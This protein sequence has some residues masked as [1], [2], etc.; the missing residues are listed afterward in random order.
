VGG[1]INPGRAARGLHH[2]P[3][4]KAGLSSERLVKLL[5]KR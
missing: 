4:G 1:D 2:Y 5:K 3:P